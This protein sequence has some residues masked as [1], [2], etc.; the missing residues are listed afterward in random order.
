MEKMHI[1]QA[2]Q[3]LHKNI[4]DIICRY[5]ESHDDMNYLFQYV[6]NLARMEKERID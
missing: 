2:K 1:R 4:I 3:D 5:A 6:E